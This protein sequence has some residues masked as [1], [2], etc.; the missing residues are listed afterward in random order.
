MVACELEERASDA[1]IDWVTRHTITA[2]NPVTGETTVI[3][4]RP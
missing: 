3:W 2:I 4:E 1:E